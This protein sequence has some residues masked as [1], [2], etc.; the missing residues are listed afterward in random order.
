MYDLLVSPDG[1]I[2][3]PQQVLDE[4]GNPDEIELSEENTHFVLSACVPEKEKAKAAK[5]Q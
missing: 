3:I 2:R 5:T 1:E 4:I